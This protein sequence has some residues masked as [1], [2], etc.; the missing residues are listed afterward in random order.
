MMPVSLK[1]NTPFARAAAMQCRGRNSYP[2]PDLVLRKPISPNRIFSGG[3]LFHRHLTPVWYGMM[4][5]GYPIYYA[6]TYS[7]MPVLGIDMDTHQK[8]YIH[9]A[10][11]WVIHYTYYTSYIA[12]HERCSRIQAA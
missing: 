7:T 1:N 3:M 11:Y 5:Y 8:P 4:R 2:P 10:P 6:M 12:H 9:H